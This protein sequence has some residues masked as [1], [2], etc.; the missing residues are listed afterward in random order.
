MQIHNKYQKK[1]KKTKMNSKIKR[2]VDQPFAEIDINQT[3]YI[4]AN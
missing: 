3:G 1:K 4:R 2:A